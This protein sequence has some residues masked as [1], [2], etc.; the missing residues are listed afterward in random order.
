VHQHQPRPHLRH[1][2]RHRRIAQPGDVVDHLRP[3]IQ[4]RA[5][6]LGFARI[7][8]DGQ[9]KLTAHRLDDGKDALHLL[10]RI[11]LG[12]AGAGALAADVE[13]VGAGGGELLGAREGRPR[14][15]EPAPVA[16]A[17][18]RH[19]QDAHDQRAIERQ[20]ATGEEPVPSAECQVPSGAGR[21][22]GASPKVRR[23]QRGG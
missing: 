16:E 19:V 15:A 9:V 2:V 14:A 13:Q 23:G 22:W 12:G 20:R 1:H 18:R 8:R 7:H 11:D 17:V 5:R 4:R 6:D 3:C 10:V 21:K